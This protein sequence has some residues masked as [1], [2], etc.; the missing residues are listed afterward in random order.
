[1]AHNKKNLQSIMYIIN[2]CGIRYLPHTVVYDMQYLHEYMQLYINIL[3]PVTPFGPMKNNHFITP[4]EYLNK[5]YI[6]IAGFLWRLY[7]VLNYICFL[8]D[9]KKNGE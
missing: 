5:C 8:V 7:T 3:S 1:M 6:P 9:M 2:V 4:K